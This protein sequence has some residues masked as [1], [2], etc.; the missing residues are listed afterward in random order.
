MGRT[1]S[2]F[3]SDCDLSSGAFSRSHLS[4]TFWA[5]PLSRTFWARPLSRCC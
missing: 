5:R 1:F 4:R 3:R 2:T